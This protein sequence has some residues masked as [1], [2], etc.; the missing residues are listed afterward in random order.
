MRPLDCA[1]PRIRWLP[2]SVQH[3]QPVPWIGKRGGAGR[4]LCPR[5]LGV[6]E[7][8][9]A[10]QVRKL[11]PLSLTCAAY[12]LPS[13]P[14]LLS[15]LFRATAPLV[16]SLRCA[17]GLP[18]FCP[19][20]AS[21][22]QLRLRHFGVNKHWQGVIAIMRNPLTMSRRVTSSACPFMHSKLWRQS[23]QSADHKYIELIRS[24]AAPC[25]F[26]LPRHVGRCE[27][28]SQTAMV[29]LGITAGASADDLSGVCC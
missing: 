25:L 18:T 17:V 24:C 26:A 27:W 2:C 11:S 20:S 4:P 3:V 28:S 1:G 22:A 15:S 12:F 21:R 14:L 10:P 6:A 16:R 5:F 7:T 9:S 13:P 23:L 8:Q 19:A 29:C